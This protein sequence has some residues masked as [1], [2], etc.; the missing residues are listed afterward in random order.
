MDMDTTVRL[1]VLF[2]VMLTLLFMKVPIFMALGGS[3]V[4]YAVVFPGSVPI[5]VF[6]QSLAQGIGKESYLAIVFYL[7][8]GEVMSCG[9]ISR[10]LVELGEAAIGWVHGSLSHINVLASVVFAAVSG[11]A[12][13]DTAAIGSLLIPAMKKQGYP[14]GY[15][16]A[17]TEMSSII[18]SIIPPSGGLVILA[19]F[20]NTSARKMLTAGLIPGL[21]VGAIELVVSYVISRRRNFPRTPWAGWGNLWYH[22]RRNI[23]AL[24]LPLGTVICLLGGIGTVTEIGAL[25]AFFAFVIA[26]CYKE[27]DLKTMV[28]CFINCTVLTGRVLC[29]VA[30]AGVFVWIISSMGAANK[31][32]NM[33]ANSGLSSSALLFLCIIILLFAGMLLNVNV[34]LTVIVPVMV[35]S[36]MAAG[37]DTLH[38]GIIA[39]I[40]CQMGVNTPP[41]GSLIYLTASIA[42]CP[43]TEVIKESIPYLLALFAFLAVLVFFP[44]IITFLPGL[45]V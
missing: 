18:S 25:S 11:S 6:T 29:S 12:N 1:I 42:E 2:A 8:M 27:M 44:Q 21:C 28:K 34:L 13:A 22:F 17:V 31:I 35:P 37:I 16:A 9:G 15:A 26:F 19:V 43:A 23:L 24:L 14:A 4:I 40:I 33:I 41:V 39:M 38:F 30:T 32:A 45:L 5:A 20:M 7:L 10:R 3:A 36:I